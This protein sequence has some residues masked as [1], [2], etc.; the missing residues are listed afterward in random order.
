GTSTTLRGSGTIIMNNN[1]VTTTWTYGPDSSGVMR[2]YRDSAGIRVPDSLPVSPF[3]A[4]G[5]MINL[6]GGGSLF[7]NPGCLGG[8]FGGYATF[9]SLMTLDDDNGVNRGWLGT[10]AAFQWL[11]DFE[12]R[13]L[14]V[15]VVGDFGGPQALRA[16]GSYLKEKGAT[17]S[18]FYT[19]NVEQYLFQQRKATR[20]YDNVAQMP[21]T[22][23]SIF[24]RSF[25]P[26]LGMTIAPRRR[27]SRL[28]QTFSTIDTVLSASALGVLNSYA[29]LGALQR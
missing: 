26:T 19:S 21:T 9:A 13:N 11:K 29:Q 12:S 28:A 23:A 6:G 16:V 5:G 7:P 27:G 10:E 2:T 22:P 4:G 25:P 15:P 8:G 3:I 17:V 20:F 14:L 24:I 1:G 18:A